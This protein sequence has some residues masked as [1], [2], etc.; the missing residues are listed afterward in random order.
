MHIYSIS[1]TKQVR[2]VMLNYVQQNQMS[3]GG[4]L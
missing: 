1:N 2:S 3:W 4:K